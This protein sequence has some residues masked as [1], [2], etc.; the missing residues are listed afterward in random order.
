MKH[1]LKI[2]AIL[3]VMF[4]LTQFIGLYVINNYSTTRIENGEVVNVSAQPLPYGLETPEIEKPSDYQSVFYMILFAFIIAITIIFFLT[5]IKAEFILRAWFFVVVT[6][7]LIIT[8]NVITNKGGFEYWVF[9]EWGIPLFATL[10]ALPL[11]FIKIFKR[12]FLIHNATELLIYPGIA[13]I[14]VPILNFWTILALLVIISVYDMWA[15][16]HSG[17]MQKMAKYQIN[18]LKIF[19]GFFV[20]YLSKK[21]RMKMKKAKKSKLKKKNIKISI[22]LLGGGDVVFP[23]ITAG[24]ILKTKIPLPFGLHEFTGGLIPALFV[25]GGAMLGLGSLFLFSQKKKFYPAMPFI[26]A[27]ILFGMILSYLFS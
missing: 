15:V 9:G 5:K 12:N 26:T 14:F 19:S 6:L 17:I 24:V 22:A 8:I 20:P 16:W 25:I 2:V 7:A 23:L 3:L 1:N 11:A 27:G 10:I 4:L 21:I 18:Q 13:A